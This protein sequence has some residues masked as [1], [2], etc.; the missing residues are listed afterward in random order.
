MSL[1][2]LIRKRKTVSPV[3]DDVAKG[4]VWACAAPED[5]LE[6]DLALIRDG[7]LKDVDEDRAL[8]ELFLLRLSLAVYAARR[9]FVEDV[10]DELRQALSRCLHRILLDSGVRSIQANPNL[11]IDGVNKRIDAYISAINTPHHLGPG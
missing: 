6:A 3:T 9:Y 10:Q 7:L 5:K 8:T 2:D 4:L 1:W 11:T